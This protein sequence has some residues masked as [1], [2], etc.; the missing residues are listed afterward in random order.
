MLVVQIFLPVFGGTFL[1]VS[2]LVSCLDHTDLFL[3]EFLRQGSSNRS[4]VINKPRKLSEWITIK[5]HFRNS[6]MA[7]NLQEKYNENAGII[8]FASLLYF[9]CFPPFYF[10]FF[11]Y[12]IFFLREYF[13][14]P[15]EA[16][17]SIYFQ[18]PCKFFSL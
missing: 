2:I 5:L 9:K 14:L 11:C 16:H 1:R 3:L 13:F 17:S 18:C 4:I 15:I 6:S 12:Y 10:C 7:I 8:L